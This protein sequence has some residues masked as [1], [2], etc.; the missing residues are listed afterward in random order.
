M[1]IHAFRVL[2]DNSSLSRVYVDEQESE[3]FNI[4]NGVIQNEVLAHFL[5]I[6]HINRLHL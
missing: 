6:I 3:P 5:F 1:E 2:Y 4:T